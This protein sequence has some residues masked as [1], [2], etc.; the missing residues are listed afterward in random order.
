MGVVGSIKMFL[1]MW[2]KEFLGGT[3]DG[4]KQWKVVPWPRLLHPKIV[5]R[6]DNVAANEYG[7]ISKVRRRGYVKVV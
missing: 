2:P 7:K 6:D 4:Q 1:W 3:R 5:A